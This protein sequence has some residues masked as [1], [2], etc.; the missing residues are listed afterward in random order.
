MKKF[1]LFLLILFC[2][3]KLYGFEL[4][5]DTTN[6]SKSNYW[7][8]FGIG[9]NYFGPT[10]CANLSYTINQNLITI[11][12]ASSEEF[13]FGVDNTNLDKPSIWLKEFG[14]L[15]G[16]CFRKDILLLSV[17]AG[18]S[19]TN[20]IIRGQNIQDHY[21]EKRNISTFGFPIEAEAMFEVSDY[22]GVGL[23][24]F[25]NLNKEKNFNGG[26]LRIKVGSL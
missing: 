11:K 23:L 12:Y 7:V 4:R 10:I 18:I 25:V 22:V 21:Y 6:E 20:G 19:Y 13:Q 24:F 1:L 14:F 15:Y 2:C 16:R 17:S 8:G 3:Q 5:L 26:M 9:G